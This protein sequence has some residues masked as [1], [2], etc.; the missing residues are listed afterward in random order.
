MPPSS[1]E[2][3]ALPAL[4]AHA[5]A[6]VIGGGIL[7][8]STLYHLAKE[9]CRDVV[10]LERQ[11]LT[12]GTTWHS[13]AQ[14]RQLR[15][16]R[17]LTELIRYSAKLYA[18]LEEETGQSTG[19]MRTGS[20]SIATNADRFTHIKRQ[21][22]LARLFGIPVNVL[23][24]AEAK[25]LWPMMNADDL[26]GAVHSPDDGRVNPSDLCQALVKGA[27]ARGARVFEHT[28][29]TGFVIEGGR[30]RG[31]ETD[32]GTIRTDVAVNCAGL[33]GRHVGRLAGVDIPLYA[34]EHFYLLT[35]PIDGITPHGP[36]LSDHDGHLYIRDEVGGLLV[37]CFEPQAR[38]VAVADLPRDFAFDLLNEDWDHFEPMMLNA[39]HRIPALETAEA[40]LLLNGPE[41]FTPDGNFLLGE[42]PGLGGFFVGC[43]MN[44]VG[45]ASGGGAG[46]A[47]ARW[48]TTGQAPSDLWSVDIRRFGPYAAN[49][50]VLRE[51][52]PEEL[53]LHYAVSY[54][55]RKPATARGLKRT[56]LHDR[57]AAKGARFGPRFGWE[58]AEW[59]DDPQNET[60]V[61]LRFGRPAWFDAEAAD[62]RAAR[63]D[64]ALFDQSTFGKILVQGPDSERLLQHLCAA[65]VAVA[66]G[67]LVYT[68]MLNDRGGYESD[69]T[70][71]RLAE[72]AYLMVT[73]TA[74][75]VRDL[76]W[77]RRHAGDLRAVATDVTGGTAVLSLMG[78]RSRDLLAGLTQADLSLEAFPPFTSQTLDVGP[79][80]VRAARLSYV[81]ELG[82]ELYV[83][84]ESATLLYDT[85]HAAAPGLRDA[86]ALA[87]T[88]LRVEKAYRAWGH[89]VTPDDTPLEAGL[90]F[91]TKLKTDIPFLGREA[92]E[93]Q[94]DAGPARRLMAFTADD[95]AAVLYG[96]EPILQDGRIVGQVTSAAH[97]HTVGRAVALGYVSLRGATAAQVAAAQGFTVEVACDSVPVTAALAAPYDPKGLRMRV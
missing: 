52:V 9:G 37:G 73:G 91:A 97:G 80:V 51:R 89:D 27:K 42:A 3:S 38:A 32:R 65:D 82:W 22:S 76:A 57:L 93:R 87:L 69:L 19:W 25:A 53:G 34:C 56:P 18:E 31:V 64:V 33:W 92:L 36:T 54:P 88:S 48:I 12:S 81:G 74:Q 16:S 62:H 21:A 23:T 45:I 58:R 43:G 47:L 75:P 24:P 67:R 79:V 90:A 29:V 8:C 2:A 50:Q 78:P 96:D 13:A 4:P 14:V 40:R 28:T 11:Q 68:P 41:S 7:G 63:D 49:R 61:S 71:H 17:N 15:S 39:L 83:P 66:P 44:S 86:G 55:G 1:T 20:L 35:K 72:D 6:V 26:V 70:V 59:F 30:V 46:R 95:P 5:G 84:V 77:L 94:R 10:L 85:L 60:D